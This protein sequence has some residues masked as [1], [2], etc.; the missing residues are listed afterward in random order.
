MTVAEAV[1][2]TK[3]DIVTIVGV[4]EVLFGSKN[5]YYIA[6]ETGAILVYATCDYKTW[7]NC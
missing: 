6:D 7:T 4:V 1:N 2:A 5:N 3:G